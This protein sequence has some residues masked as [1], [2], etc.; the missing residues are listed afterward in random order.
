[1]T[2]S[3]SC[4]DSLQEEERWVELF[5]DLNQMMATLQADCKAQ[6]VRALQRDAQIDSLE[7]KLDQTMEKLDRLLQLGVAPAQVNR[8]QD[9]DNYCT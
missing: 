5:T 1:M 4:F 7:S 2:F 9:P 8:L 6:E 3:S